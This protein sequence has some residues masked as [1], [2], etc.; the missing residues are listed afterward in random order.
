[1][2]YNN[3][4]IYFEESWNEP[5]RQKEPATGGL[6]RKRTSLP[7]WPKDDFK[8]SFGQDEVHTK[9]KTQKQ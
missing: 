9:E 8:T 3:D 1:M 2:S 7:D 4:F 6:Q 5:T